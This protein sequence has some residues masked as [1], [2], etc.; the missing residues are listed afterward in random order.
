LASA[1]TGCPL[2]PDLVAC[3]EVGLAGEIRQVGRTGQRLR[4]AARLGFRRALVPLSAP[5]T[6]AAVAAERVATLRDAVDRALTGFGVPTGSPSD[7]A[8]T[9]P[10]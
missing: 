8:G 6:D 9:F 3:G 2:P 4:E 10:G 5:D 1:V 7:G